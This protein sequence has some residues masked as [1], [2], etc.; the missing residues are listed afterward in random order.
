MTLRDCDL[1][2]EVDVS[3]DNAPPCVIVG[4]IRRLPVD[5]YTVEIARLPDVC[6]PPRL[7][8]PDARLSLTHNGAVA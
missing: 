8:T 4:R 5:V 3:I 2:Y 1:H 7:L 6:T